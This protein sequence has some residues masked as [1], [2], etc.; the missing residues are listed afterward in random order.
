LEDSQGALP[1]L[2]AIPMQQIAIITDEDVEVQPKS[3]G[4]V[5]VTNRQEYDGEVYIE[6]QVRSLP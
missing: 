5:P 2:D 1:G 4:Y 3:M 6:G